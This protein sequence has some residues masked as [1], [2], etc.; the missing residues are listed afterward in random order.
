MKQRLKSETTKFLIILIV[1]GIYLLFFK[2]TKFKIPCIFHELT[3]LLCPGCGISR[4]LANI[5]AGDFFSAY[6]YNKL[7][8]ITLPLILADFL[9]EEIRYIKT[10]SR[11]ILLL[12]KIFVYVE[13][14]ALLLFGIVRNIL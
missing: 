11:R 12:S 10:G 7:L 9:L 6:G 3:G 5:S 14:I 2:Y 8:F 4:M 1:G 13:I